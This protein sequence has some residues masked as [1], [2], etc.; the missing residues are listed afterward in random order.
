MILHTYTHTHP[1]NGPLDFIWDYLGELVPEPI[2]I[3]LKQKTL[4]VALSGPHANLH[5]TLDR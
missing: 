3:L 2:C 4:A 1:F 5:L